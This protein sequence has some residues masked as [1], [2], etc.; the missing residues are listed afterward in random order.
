MLAYYLEWHMR[1][2]LAPILFDDHRRE[3]AAAA[4][5]SPVAPA[6]R[7]VAARRK[8]ASKRTEDGLPA[9]SFQS[10]LAELATFTRNAM[11][12]E[13]APED[14]FFLYPQPTIVQSRAFELLGVPPR[15]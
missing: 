14:L 11:A 9:L 7:S 12:L 1:Q 5:S 15:L 13:R 8:A 6:Q 4:R 10:M 3:E 2:A